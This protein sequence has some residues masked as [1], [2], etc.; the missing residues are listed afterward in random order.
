MAKKR[1]ISKRNK[2]AL[3]K[4]D[5]ENKF[6]GPFKNKIFEGLGEK[7]VYMNEKGFELVWSNVVVM[8]LALFLIMIL[9]LF[10]TIG[11][12]GFW[13]YMKSFFSYSNVDGVVSSC[14][15]LVTSNSQYNFCC[16]KKNVKY[17]SDGKKNESEFTC[18][19]LLNKDFA[20]GINSLDC[21]G[22]GC[23]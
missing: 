1:F 21:A 11:G 19:E 16:E 3:L 20:K 23:G 14:N 22:V 9:I 4:K 6:S 12:Q 15:L 13:D 17:Y 10:F 7:G 5:Q 2:R 18:L 8:I